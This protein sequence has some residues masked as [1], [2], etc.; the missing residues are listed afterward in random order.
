MNSIRP[1]QGSCLC[2][3]NRSTPPHFSARKTER[4]TNKETPKPCHQL[5]ST[6]PAQVLKPKTRGCG[7]SPT[8]L[9][10]LARLVSSATARIFK[11]SLTKRYASQANAAQA[12]Q[13]MR[14]ASTLAMASA[15]KEPLGSTIKALST[16]QATRSISRSMV[17]G[18]SRLSC[19]VASWPIRA[20]AIL[21]SAPRV[22][23]SLH[24]ALPCSPLSKCPL[25]HPA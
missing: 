3:A 11:R 2:A 18:F 6:S 21:R 8:I 16:I 9:L 13:I 22:S 14:L 25:A 10:I 19:R 4:R 5:P 20:R 24:R 1:A 17:P 23:W 7:S 12:T 15:F